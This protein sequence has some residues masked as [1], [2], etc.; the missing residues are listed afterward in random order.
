MA[1]ADSTDD[2]AR[3]GAGPHADVS[4]AR[5]AELLRGDT[6]TAYPAL[7]ELRA[8]H[9]PSLLAYAR[10]CTAGES[11]ARQLAAHTFA[12]AAREIARGATGTGR[13]TP[14]RHRLLAL[15][16]ESARDWAADDRSGGLDP[17]LL[18][19]LHTPGSRDPV[20]PPRTA[21]PRGA[22][23]PLLT[24]FRH[25]PAP[26]R[27]L[28]WYGVVER[29]SAERTA[30]LLGV[31]REDV[32]PGIPAALHTLA[33][34][35][36]RARLAASPDPRCADLQLLI[37]EAVQPGGLLQPEGFLHGADPHTHIA[38]CPHCTAAHEEQ[39]ALRERPR[40]TLAEGLLPWAGAA[41]ARGTDPQ[42][43]P[44]AVRASDEAWPPARRFALV[45]AALGVALAP[46]LL[47]LLG[48]GAAD[49]EPAG[50]DSSPPGPPPVSVTAT[51]SNAPPASPPSIPATAEPSSSGPAQRPSPP[52][53]AH[54]AAPPGGDY[55]QVVNVATG[56]CLDIRDGRVEEGADVVTAPCSSSPT[57]RWRVDP[58]R[59][60]V[61]SYADSGYCLDSRGA[62]ER[63]VGIR[64]CDAVGGRGGWDL[65]FAVDDAGRVRPVTD[66]GTAVTPAG[67]HDVVLRALDGGT[68]QRWRAGAR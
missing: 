34:S 28:V 6:V 51:V 64:G 11:A 23:P 3:T 61:Q 4:D 36:L 45:S 18:L 7:R 14:L 54:P 35:C 16:G 29:E 42:P 48:G 24:A 12:R 68:G 5:L 20:P 63:G 22:V 57:Q 44:S 59:G 65:R 8:R 49:R 56:R 40:T 41:Y 25:L 1:R 55:A 60:V 32:V 52:R 37:E 58:E 53:T 9:R 67:G 43:P 21:D 39:R 46:L 66:F 26:A 27:G 2:D 30:V 17:G 62:L 19:A 50:S 13:G 15:A 47:F 38:R 10:L 31:N 33:R